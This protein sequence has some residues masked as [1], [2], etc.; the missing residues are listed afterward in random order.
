[1]ATLKQKAVFSATVKNLKQKNPLNKKELLLSEGYSVSVA[2]KPSLVFDSKYFQER[3]AA[4]DDTKILEKWYEW[5]T[6]ET[7]RR[8]S[9]Q[10]GENIMK[11]K[12]RYPKQKS[13][14]IGLFETID[15]IA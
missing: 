8:V 6:D 1:M 7:D 12:D 11:L 13:K 4:I 2:D 5:A 3:L 10:C 9:V 15:E 14:M